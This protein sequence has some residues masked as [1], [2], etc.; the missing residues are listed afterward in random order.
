MRPFDAAQHLGREHLG[1]ALVGL[2]HV[3][4]ARAR[5]TGRPRGPAAAAARAPRTAARRRSAS[6]PSTAISL[7]RTWMSA[8]G[9][10]A[11]ISRSSSSRWPSS[12]TMRWLPGT[13]MRTCV[14]ATKCSGPQLGLGSG[15]LT[16][17]TVAR[18]RQSP[19]RFGLWGMTSSW[20]RFAADARQHEAAAS[21]AREGWLR[22]AAGDDAT[23]SGTLLDLAE[24]GAPAVLTL[25]SGRRHR[26]AIW[27]VASDCVAVRHDDGRVSWIAL[28]AVAVIAGEPGGRSV[29]VSTRRAES[30]VTFAGCAERP[31]RGPGDRRAVRC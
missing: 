1:R 9:N 31:G 22:Q 2:H 26:V 18:L 29:P 20:D 17:M 30:D 23:L 27:R 8:P 15:T 16:Q 24:R 6:S 21:R 19:L 3:D 12:P 11:S 5:P 28:A 25:R 10:A 7:P 13:L 4:R 14:R